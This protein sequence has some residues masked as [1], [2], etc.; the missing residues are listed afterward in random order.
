MHFRQ[1]YHN[2]LISLF[3]IIS[4]FVLLFQILSDHFEIFFQI[5]FCAIAFGIAG[6]AVI[7]VYALLRSRRSVSGP[8]FI[9]FATFNM[10]IGC[11]GLL[12][13]TGD[14]L[15]APYLTPA[16]FT[17]GLTMYIMLFRSFRSGGS[18]IRNPESK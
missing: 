6:G 4:W 3:S 16:G 5:I 13:S 12:N 8:F 15:P 18:S 11:Y 10:L 14:G 17:V 2:L 7:M 1:F 9:F